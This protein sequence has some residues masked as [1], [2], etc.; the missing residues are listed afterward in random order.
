M[1][2][3]KKYCPNVFVLQTANTYQRDDIVGIETKYGKVNEHVIHNLVK[4]GADGFNYYSITRADG[5]TSQERAKR[6]AEK[7]Q[8]WAIS[9]ANKSNE[10]WEESNE[11]ADFLALAEPIKIGH[12]SE[13]RHR[14]LIERNHSR[15]GK[16]IELQDKADSHANKAEYWK[17]QD[18][19]IDLSM[20]ESIDFF[21]SKLESA[22]AIQAAYKDG[23]KERE[24]SYS[25][26]YASKDV[27]DLTKKVQTAMV[28]WG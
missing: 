24:H 11:G 6:K 25:L 23:T 18:G 19:K 26:A 22:I 3:Y 17:G 21:Q 15:M 8:D 9:A 10:K 27:K 1:N 28:L 13:R 2:T 4:Q 5:F 7:F 20:P 16:S 14:A 12:H